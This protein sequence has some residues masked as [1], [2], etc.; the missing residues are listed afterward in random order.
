MHSYLGDI[1]SQKPHSFSLVCFLMPAGILF[2][3]RDDFNSLEFLESGLSNPPYGKFLNFF[4]SLQ[5][6]FYI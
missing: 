6:S 5:I 1:K 3:E 2:C 4:L